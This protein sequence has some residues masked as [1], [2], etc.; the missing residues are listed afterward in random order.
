MQ[1]KLHI[2]LGAFVTYCAP[3]LVHFEKVY[4][5]A[6]L[7]SNMR[8]ETKLSP[9][10]IACGKWDY[11]CTGSIHVSNA[12][13]RNL[14]VIQYDGTCNLASNAMHITCIAYLCDEPFFSLSVVTIWISLYIAKSFASVFMCQ[15]AF[16]SFVL[17]KDLRGDSQ[18]FMDKGCNLFIRQYCCLIL[19]LYVH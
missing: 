3:I 2:Y 12:T 10:C 13:G 1:F 5:D 9:L 11:I 14:F 15:W 19:Y 18:K 4:A 16:L 8:M 7:I 6:I 17:Y